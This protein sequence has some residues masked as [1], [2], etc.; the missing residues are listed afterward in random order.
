MD[1]KINTTNVCNT[2]TL[3]TGSYHQYETGKGVKKKKSN[4]RQRVAIRFKK[5]IQQYS[6]FRSNT[7]KPKFHKNIPLSN[8]NLLTWCKYLHLPIKDVL[9]RDET[10]PHKHKQTLFIYNVKPAYMSR[11]H[12]VCTYVKN[13]IINYFDGFGMPPFQEIVNHAKKEN[14]T[15]LHQNNQIQIL[16][17]PAPKK[18]TTR[19]AVRDKQ[20]TLSPFIELTN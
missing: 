1:K 16:E 15:L 17:F 3:I 4:K 6:N 11:S 14:I 19:N 9:S 8:H 5:P 13:G 18:L 12:W 2:A 20:T 10:V 7:L